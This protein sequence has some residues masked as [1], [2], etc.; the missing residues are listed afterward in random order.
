MAL[1]PNDLIGSSR[2]AVADPLYIKSGI[3]EQG[4]CLTRLAHRRRFMPGHGAADAL[5]S[6]AYVNSQERQP[7]GEFP[8]HAFIGETLLASTETHA[9]SK[10]FEI[11]DNRLRGFTLR[12]QPSGHRS[13]YARFGRNRRIAL[14]TVESLTPLEARERCRKVLGN[15]VH[16]NHPLHGIQGSE[17]MTLGMFIADEY[18]P[19][20]NASR[21]RTSANTLEKLHRHFRTWF[22]EPLTAITVE[23]VESWKAR[24]LSDG[25]SPSTV[26]RDLFTLSSVLRRAVKAG[27]LTDNPVRRVDKPRIDRRGQIRFLDEVEE[28]QLRMAM[29]ARDERMKRRREAINA[30]RLKLGEPLLARLPYFGDHLTPAVLLTMNTGVRRG[31]LLKLRWASVDFNRRLLT[32]EGRNAKSR[33][34]R[35]VPLND[36]ATNVLRNWR[37]QSA[38]KGR[39]FGF[40]TGFKTAWAK[41]LNRAGITRFRW[42]DLRHHFASRLVQ[43]GVPLNTVRDLLG[44]STVQM[45]LRYAHLAPDQRREAVAK[46][47]EKP[48]LALTLRLPWSAFPADGSNYLKEMVEREDSI[49]A[50]H[51]TVF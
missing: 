18:T 28:S 20:I 23:R 11:Y 25:R 29:L 15:V 47:N 13:Y 38:D 5:I 24:R 36:E 33:R 2:I 19:W 49:P 1:A 37:D 4:Y 31:E 10:P 43:R 26:L 3:S 39:V 40:A 22:A 21:P 50:A 7:I 44:H 35:H 42:H 32:V 17:G 27:E 46:L 48:I 30:Q 12:V 45:S 6:A 41:L 14:G 9:R 34:T 8:M 51:R 16:G